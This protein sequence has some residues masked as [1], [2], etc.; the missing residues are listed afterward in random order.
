MVGFA[1]DS[2]PHGAARTWL[3]GHFTFGSDCIRPKTTT[4]SAYFAQTAVI[5]VL[6]LEMARG[7]FGHLLI[8]KPQD[9][10]T[11]VSGLAL[12]E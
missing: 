8:S 6:T 3:N 1:R 12:H 11:R 7:S 2:V 9:D 4:Q 10:S 5:T